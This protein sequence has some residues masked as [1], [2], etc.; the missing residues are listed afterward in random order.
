MNDKLLNDKILLI[1]LITNFYVVFLDFTSTWV[2]VSTAHQSDWLVAVGLVTEW[3][4]SLVGVCL[5]A[6]S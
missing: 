3:M 1:N 6:T 5:M 4:V 2:Q